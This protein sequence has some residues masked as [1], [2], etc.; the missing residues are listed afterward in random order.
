DSAWR[1][2]RRPIPRSPCEI[3]RQRSPEH[4]TQYLAKCLRSILN[5]RIACGS[6]HSAGPAFW[7]AAGA[8]VR[9]LCSSCPSLQ[10]S[11]FGDKA[12]GNR[13]WARLLLPQACKHSL[14]LEVIMTDIEIIGAPQSPFV[15]AARMACAEKGVAYRLTPAMPHT[16]EVDCIHPFG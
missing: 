10:R 14:S 15:R 13:V 2:A 16:P 7:R 6:A 3:G 12:R 4:E 1:I 11:A 5:G 8:T 9:R